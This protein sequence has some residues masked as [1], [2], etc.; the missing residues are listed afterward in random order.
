M[1]FEVYN[2]YTEEIEFT[3]SIDECEIFIANYGGGWAALRL[4]SKG[5]S[6]F[7]D[8]YSAIQG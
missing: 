3:G 7:D 6:E 2:M 8:Y 5:N 1:K 4:R